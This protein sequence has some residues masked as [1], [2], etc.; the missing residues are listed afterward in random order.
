MRNLDRWLRL[1][2]QRDA[3][4]MRP[5][6]LVCWRRLLYAPRTFTEKL[7]APLSGLYC[8]ITDHTQGKSWSVAFPEPTLR[9]RVQATTASFS[10][11]DRRGVEADHILDGAA[12]AKFRENGCDCEDGKV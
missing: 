4:R 9:L 5:V 10:D 12:R 1:R 6:R 3:A 8:Q 7:I 11:D 2:T